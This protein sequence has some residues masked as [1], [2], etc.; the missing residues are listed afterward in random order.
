MVVASTHHEFEC[1]GAARNR[2]PPTESSSHT[3]RATH[4][5]HPPSVYTGR[6]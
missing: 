6:N 3:V 5:I 2:Y 1:R 4:P